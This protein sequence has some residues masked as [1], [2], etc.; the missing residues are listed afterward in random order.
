MRPG[1]FLEAAPLAIIGGHVTVSAQHR[2]QL[3]IEVEQY[4]GGFGDPP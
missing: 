3:E 4:D 1:Q 2:R